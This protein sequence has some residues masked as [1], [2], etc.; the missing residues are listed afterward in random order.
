MPKSKLRNV[1]LLRLLLPM[2]TILLV[3]GVL[4]YAL[5]V[6]HYFVGKDRALAEDA[7]GLAR[8]VRVIDGEFKL[9]LPRV[10][11]EMFEWDGVDREY[12]RVDSVKRGLIAKDADVPMPGP[13]A[14]DLPPDQ[15]Y[16][17][18]G[19]VKGEDVRIVA[20]RIVAAQDN[21]AW[22]RVALTNNRRKAITKGFLAAVLLPQLALIVITVLVIRSGVKSGLAPLDRLT[23]QIDKRNPNDMALLQPEGVPE[24]ALPLINAFNELLARLAKAA[25]AQQ[26]FIADAAHQLRT[27]L[28]ALKAQM[29]WIGKESDPEVRASALKQLAA[30]VNRTARLS[31]QLL[32]L[33][34]AEPNGARVMETVDLRELAFE[35]GSQWVSNALHN[36]RDLGFARADSPI[37]IHADQIMLRELI[38][39][40]LD[41]AL[42]YGGTRITLQ[43][44]EDRAQ[45]KAVLAVEDDGPGIPAA[46]RER[47]FERFHRVPGS[48]GEGSGL[49]LAIVREIARSHNADIALEEPAGGGVRIALRFTRAG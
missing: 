28:A 11:I 37:L 49:G 14:A 1:L 5:V 18:D 36:G 39:N 12:F 30:S 24:E 47:V 48:S 8:Q 45:G 15:P 7:R 19:K 42:R 26:R 33:A 31:N 23:A 6:R 34:R 40:L 2:C 4:T 21:E 17:Y 3:S 13:A 46:E 44:D 16:F 22:V 20:F 43:V 10:A 25:D 35:T 38:N 41:N 29:D 9:S 32:L 27:P